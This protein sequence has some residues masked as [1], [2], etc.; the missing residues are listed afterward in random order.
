MIILF[1]WTK[2]PCHC[3]C[4]FPCLC[5]FQASVLLV[6]SWFQFYQRGK[7]LLLLLL[8]FRMQPNSGLLDRVIPAQFPPPFCFCSL[9]QSL[10]HLLSPFHWHSLWLSVLLVLLSALLVLLS[11]VVLHWTCSDLSL[12][13]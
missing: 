1:A 7:T 4:P 10:S 12:L 8:T 3:H 5:P 9:R 13:S 2:C 11:L 6:S